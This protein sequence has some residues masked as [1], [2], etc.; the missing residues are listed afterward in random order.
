[1]LVIMLS[2][3]KLIILINNILADSDFL[4]LR[5]LHKV[6]CDLHTSNQKQA[7]RGKFIIV[8]FVEK[9]HL[10]LGMQLPHAHPT[11]NTCQNFVSSIYVKQSS[12]LLEGV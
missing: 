8:H 2:K 3:K 4:S 1:M 7:T 5:R 11:V 9:N 10:L 12:N 6:I